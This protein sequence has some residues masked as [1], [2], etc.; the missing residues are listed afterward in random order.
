MVLCNTQV[1]LQRLSKER[2]ASSAIVSKWMPI[3]AG[4]KPVKTEDDVLHVRNLPTFN[5][6]LNQP[7][8]ELL[9]SYLTVPYLRVPLIAKFFASN[10]RIHSLKEQQLQYVLDDV[11]FQPDRF[12]S[13]GTEVAPTYIPT[14]KR[15]ELSTPYGMLIN[16]LHRSPKVIVDSVSELLKQALDL[17]TGAPEESTLPIM[18]YVIQL[19]CRMES[20]LDMMIRVT[21]GTHESFSELTALR[22]VNVSPE[23]LMVSVCKLVVQDVFPHAKWSR[24]WY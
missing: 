10:D 18:L 11:L 23:S 8:S 20:Y 7:D 3:K 14:R 1:G 22:G 2:I 9:M 17:D 4:E 21:N 24:F 6:S 19:A 5:D 13:D 16:E 12:A 15:Q